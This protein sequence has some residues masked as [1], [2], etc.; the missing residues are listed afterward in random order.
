MIR[1]ISELEQFRSNLSAKKDSARPCVV[2]CT[3]ASCQAL[4][5]TGVIG[6]LRKELE[7][8][9]LANAVDIKEAGCLGFCNRGPLAV[10]HP[11]ELCYLGLTPDDAPEIVS[12]TLKGKLVERLTYFDSAT[13]KNIPHLPDIPFYKAQTRILSGNN[14]KISPWSIDDYI[15]SGGYSALAKAFSMTPEAVL[16]EIKKSNLRGR[17]GGGFPTGRKWETARNAAE[18]T[19]YVIVNAH[20]GEPAAFMDRSILTGNPH[21]VLEG[22]IIGAYAISASRGFIYIRHDSL[23]LSDIVANAVQQARDYGFLGENI[24]SSGFDFKLELHKDIGIFVSGESSALMTAI[25]GRVPEPRPKYIRTSV[26]GIWGKPSNLNNVE[27]W[28]N[29][30]LIINKGAEWYASIGTEGSKGTKLI[31]LSGNITNAGVIEVPLGT[32]LRDIVYRIGGGV[33]NGK[34]LKAVHIGGPLGGS[35]P[36]KLLDTPLDFDEL[37]KIGAP[38]GAG[39][40]TVMDESI[41]MVDMAKYFLDFLSG[42]SCGKCVPCREGLKQMR[43]ILDKIIKGKGSEQDLKLL[44]EIAEVTR[45]ASLC[46]LGR[47]ATNPVLSTLRY[48]K[49]EYEAH[50]NEKRCLGGGHH[51]VTKE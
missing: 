27:T 13:G 45:D 5:A 38:M 37:S 31:S 44:L 34:K 12:Q 24:L 6:A 1:T 42:E 30:P 20:E 9:R 23:R 18:P 3:G 21:S 47:T 25:E 16:S 8:H 26:S 29:V 28:A 39:G 41:C 36:D 48:F 35:I 17:G 4:G 51:Q 49:N 2:V 50:I 33:D 19:K 40:I 10:V 32:S 7:K 43:K 46:A 15:S 14:A 22:L 11:G